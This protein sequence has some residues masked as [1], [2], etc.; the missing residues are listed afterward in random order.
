VSWVGT[1]SATAGWLQ[2]TSIHPSRLLFAVYR[3]A[4]GPDGDPSRGR[5]WLDNSQFQPPPPP[6]PY[7]DIDEDYHSD[8]RDAETR[9]R[10]RSYPRTERGFQAN[11]RRLKKHLIRQQRLLTV[12]T[13]KCMANCPRID[14]QRLQVDDDSVFWSPMA[15]NFKITLDHGICQKP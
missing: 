4:V 10:P 6:E 1:D 3:A 5:V 9:T 2:Q 7:V 15:L 14:P 12:M 11:I 8:E 13:N